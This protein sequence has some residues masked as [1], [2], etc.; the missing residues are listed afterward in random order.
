MGKIVTPGYTQLGDKA[1]RTLF[2]STLPKNY[3]E[4]RTLM[5]RLSFCSSAVADYKR[6]VKPIE[7]LL[8]R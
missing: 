1:V 7:R 5:G 2:G 4:L 8:R 6:L 3:D